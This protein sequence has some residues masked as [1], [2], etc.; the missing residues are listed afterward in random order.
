MLQV[1]SLPG[2]EDALV[3]PSADGGSD[4]GYESN[5]ATRGRLLDLPRMQALRN[6]QEQRAGS[7]PGS[8]RG[9][10]LSNLS[11]M[12]ENAIIGAV[13]RR[14]ETFDEKIA[15]LRKDVLK[16]Q[17][18]DQVREV[19][20]DI[21]KSISQVKGDVDKSVAGLQGAYKALSEEM[22]EQIK[23]VQHL[24]GRDSARGHF[25]EDIRL[26]LEQLERGQ[27]QLRTAQKT[28]AISTEDTLKKYDH[29]ILKLENEHGDRRAHAE[30]TGQNIDIL[31]Q[32]LQ[33]I[34]QHHELA[35]ALPQGES[36]TN[37]EF[38][39]GDDS[40]HAA[41]EAQVDAISAKLDRLSTESRDVRDVHSAVAAHDEGIKAL[42]TLFNQ[43]H[44]HLQT[45]SN[46]VQGTD[47]EGRIKDLHKAHQDH[48]ESTMAHSE[49]LQVLERDLRQAERNHEQLADNVQRYLGPVNSEAVAPELEP[50]TLHTSDGL[51]VEMRVEELGA[52]VL[53]LDDRV[54]AAAAEARHSSE[55]V[56]RI[57]QVAPGSQ[58]TQKVLD[59]EQRAAHQEECVTDILKRVGSLE[60]NVKMLRPGTGIG[61]TANPRAGLDTLAVR[62][63]K[64][65]AQ[66]NQI[67]DGYS[68]SPELH[69]PDWRQGHA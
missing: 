18:S 27:T 49:K 10:G 25:E 3:P 54:A 12:R 31:H 58:L 41:L 11:A 33:E 44:E 23:T 55:L 14:L 16:T 37:K 17:A 7:Q 19:R 24:S 67:A 6:R 59:Q 22:Q 2:S 46:R 68:G 51:S 29:R 52:S 62:V 5:L 20:A 47:W 9:A 63:G 40:R 28:A 30:Q 8:A 61:D 21:N 39:T 50:G 42:R 26:K 36:S 56:A 13:Q 38:N 64:L 32:R 57:E 69:S 34:E 60:L 66:I 53:D 43:K 65:E 15:G 1:P 48:S 4:G 35:L 45:L